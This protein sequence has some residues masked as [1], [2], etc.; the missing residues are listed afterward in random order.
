MTE[1]GLWQLDVLLA[2]D[3]M[4]DRIHF[5]KVIILSEFLISQSSLFHSITVEGKKVFL[6]SFTFIGGILL[7]C[8]VLY[9]ILCMGIIEYRHFRDCDLVFC[10]NHKVFYTNVAVEKPPSLVQPCTTNIFVFFIMQ[11]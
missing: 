4:N 5:L 2:D 9:D 10:E 1:V 11:P 6:K 8:F 7:H 3:L